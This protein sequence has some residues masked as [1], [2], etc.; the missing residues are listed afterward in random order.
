MV[1]VT[2]GGTDDPRVRPAVSL[3][4]GGPTACLET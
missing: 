1:R 3:L 4:R 2:P